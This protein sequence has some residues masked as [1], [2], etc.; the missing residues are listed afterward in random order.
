MAKVTLLTIL[1]LDIC[2]NKNKRFRKYEIPMRP[3]E[4]ERLYTEIKSI[5]NVSL[6][7]GFLYR[8]SP[9]SKV[10]WYSIGQSIG[11]YN[12]GV[13]IDGTKANYGGNIKSNYIAMLSS[14]YKINGN[15]SFKFDELYVD[16]VMNTSMIQLDFA[17]KSNNGYKYMMSL[18]GIRQDAVANEVPQNR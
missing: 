15:L 9:R 3:A 14:T 10:E 12:Q 7:G 8:I 16:N 13:N 6:E 4:V 17:K 18:Q 11:I 2:P 1:F 5:K